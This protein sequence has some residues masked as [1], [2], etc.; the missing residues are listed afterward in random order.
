MTKN[1]MAWLMVA[2]TISLMASAQ[3]NESALNAYKADVR[4]YERAVKN[5][6]QHQKY[7]EGIDTLT[8][9][10]D[11]SEKTTGYPSKDLASYYSARA[12]G[13]SHMKQYEKT[14]TDI[15]RALALLQ[16]AGD[17]AK[18]DLSIAWMQLSQAYYYLDKKDETMQAADKCVE[19]A[20]DYYG[21][22]HSET[23]DAYNYRSNIAG[24]LNQ[25]TVALN[26]RKAIFSIIQKNVE[27]NFVYL[28][29][30]ERTAY[31]NKNLGATTIMYAFAHKLQEFDSE[32]TDAL[33]DQQLLAKG[34][35]LT[36]ESALQRTIDNDSL[37]SAQ[38]KKIRQLRKRASDA[39]TPPAQANAAT[40]EADRL[41][42]ELG[43][44][45]N[46]LHQ[47]MDF[48]Q[49][50]YSDVRAKLT[51]TD[52]AIEFV[53]YRV[54]KDSTM[55]AALIMSPLWNHVHFLPLIEKKELESSP[56]NLAER[57][58]QPIIKMAGS[59]VQ[60]IYFAP[61]GELY[62]LPI[63]SL[64]LSD[65]R[66]IGEVYKMYR[67][68]STRWLALNTEP[69]EG[70]D[71]VVYGGLAY[72]TSI[73]AMKKDATRYPQQRG[74]TRYAYNLRGALNDGIPYLAGTKSEAQNIVNTINNTSHKGM[75]AE[76][77]LA[78]QGTEA[79]FKN[80]SGQFKRIIH[81]ATHGFY[82]SVPT[83]ASSAP[84][85]VLSRCGLL[86]AGA[87][88]KYQG[89]TLPQG[90]EDGILTAA[91][92][93]TL[94]LRGLDLTTLS[95][96]ETAQG[97]ITSEGVFGLQRGFKKAGAQSILMSLWKVDD[98]ATCLLMTEFYKNWIAEKMN[99][100]DALEAAKQTVR[101]HTEKGWN[102][103]KYWA[104]F[105]LLDGLE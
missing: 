12:N 4:S 27:R 57:I 45:A 28:T 70:K 34:L 104:A 61:S 33:F 11:R 77:L 10:I 66:L 63:E 32:F 90:I 46:G 62:Q 96:C 103:P 100:H 6:I 99:K 65:G 73:E 105:I 15:Q 54:G 22:L 82:Q 81:V 26:D 21:P 94:D 58:W 91:E 25:K 31:W 39:Q 51:A 42:R 75:H 89:L 2:C 60:R 74:K 16:Q 44:S 36:A 13:Y 52:L 95:A 102:D 56:G 55:Y 50:H 69:V 24:F 19:T 20:I 71:A 64:Q 3:L 40:L 48:L 98:E 17:A 101:S 59:N 8:K 79:S 37:L 53:D 76:A 35:L 9:L 23:Q 92:I 87:D 85:D 43:E 7:S 80:L 49:V 67:V 97:D 5:I 14:V 68:S 38:Y 84:V 29:A 83:A 93:A 41:E 1:R 72:D 47:F 78:D 18:D 86:F 88:N 30:T